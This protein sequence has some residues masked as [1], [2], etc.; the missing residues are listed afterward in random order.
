MALMCACLGVV[1]SVR[2]QYVTFKHVGL[3]FG[4]LPT[5]MIILGYMNLIVG[6]QLNLKVHVDVKNDQLK[7]TKAVLRLSRRH[8]HALM[9]KSG[10]YFRSL[11][12]TKPIVKESP[13][14]LVHRCPTIRFI[15]KWSQNDHVVQLHVIVR[16]VANLEPQP[17]KRPDESC[18]S[19]QKW[20]DHLRFEHDHKFH[21]SMH[22]R[23]MSEIAN[24]L[25]T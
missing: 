13:I 1:R 21:E 18:N 25:T 17:L 24:W 4:A 14:Y 3:V 7:A 15:W 8:V 19:I 9:L 5:S 6:H 22:A 16:I 12:T 10:F 23:N 20:L 11:T 2:E